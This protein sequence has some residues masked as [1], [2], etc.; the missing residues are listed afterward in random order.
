MGRGWAELGWPAAPPP[1]AQDEMAWQLSDVTE[2]PRVRAEVRRCLDAGGPSD[3]RDRLLLVL[4][5]MASNALRHGGGRVEA[6]VRRAGDAFLVAVSDG[7]PAPRRRRP[8]TA[9]PVRV[10]WA[11]TSSP[12][13]RPPTAG[14]STA[15]PRP[16]GPSSPRTDPW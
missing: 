14:T 11:S 4:D 3:L 2:L 15:T 8:S 13:C 6:A 10:A 1:P 5:E 16:S 9:T 12:S 7:T